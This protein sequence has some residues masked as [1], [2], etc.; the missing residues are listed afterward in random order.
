MI[1]CLPSDQVPMLKE[2]FEKGTSRSCEGRLRVGGFVEDWRREM[3]F[4]NHCWSHYHDTEGLPEAWWGAGRASVVGGKKKVIIQKTVCDVPMTTGR[5]LFWRQDL[6]GTCDL[7]VGGYVVEVMFGKVGHHVCMNH[8][9]L[10]SFNS[11][12]SSCSTRRLDWSMTPKS[13]T[14]K[15]MQVEHGFPVSVLRPGGRRVLDELRR[16]SRHSLLSTSSSTSRPKAYL[17]AV[18]EKLSGEFD[19]EI[20]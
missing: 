11:V 6:C 9:E 20:L 12:R 4:C 13:K 16:H 10:P 8:A 17:H 3:K 2:F 15:T 1:A 5:E 18:N 19:K 14:S 7:S